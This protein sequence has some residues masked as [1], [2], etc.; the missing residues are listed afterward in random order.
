M[1]VNRNFIVLCTLG[2]NIAATQACAETANFY[3][4]A[5]GKDISFTLRYLVHSNTT[6]SAFQG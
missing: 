3:S 2:L 1:Q 6:T 4:C 5:T